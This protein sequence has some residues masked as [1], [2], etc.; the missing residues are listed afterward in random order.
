M[1]IGEQDKNK[2]GRPQKTQTFHKDKGKILQKEYK[3]RRKKQEI[4]LLP[5]PILV[6]SL[7]M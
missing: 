3:K 4:Y 1:V 5:L 2:S 6:L 7:E